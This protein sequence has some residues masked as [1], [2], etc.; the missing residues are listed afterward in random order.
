MTTFPFDS[1]RAPASVLPS[2]SPPI[3]TRISPVRCSSQDRVL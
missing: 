3:I 2:P 1:G